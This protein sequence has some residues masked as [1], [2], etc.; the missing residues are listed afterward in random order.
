VPLWL[1]A[2][3]ASAALVVSFLVAGYFLTRDRAPEKAERL[4]P[5]Q[6]QAERLRPVQVCLRGLALGMLLLTLV[7]ALL[8]TRDPYRNFSM[9]A[10][11]ILF[12]LAFTY[13][14]ALVGNVYAAINPW[15]VLAELVGRWW[16]GYL[17]GRVRYPERLDAWP[18]LLLYFGFIAYE[19]FG[20]V[21]P[22]GFGH[23]LAGYTL[24]NLV[25][26]WLVGAQAWF[27]HGELFSVLLRLVALLAPV[28]ARREE[29]AVQFALRRPGAGA[30]M[31]RPASLALVLF[32]LF[33]LSS[34]AFDGLHA[35][36]PWFA[37]FW[38]DPL[39]VVTALAGAKPIE[40]YVSLLPWYKA[41]QLFCLA[42]SPLLYF[43][44]YLGAL[45]L[46]R[47]LAGSSRPLRE[48]ALDFAYTL[49]PIAFV[50]HVAHYWTLIL[51]Q[52]MK[53]LSLASDPFGWHWNLFGTRELFRAPLIPDL[54]L[55]WHVQVGLIVLGHVASVILAHRVA[56]WVFG[57][58]AMA[59]QVPMLA[60]M[61]AFTVFGLW[62]LAQPLESTL[63]R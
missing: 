39:G 26:V 50:Y 14:T 15:R 19:L 56:L 57:A 45:A 27:R 16:P 58:R 28:D 12:V 53:I 23:V 36:R 33:M 9:T 44:L 24:L 52:G 46:A 5:V 48:L 8:G 60:L 34:T 6:V 40:A 59:S 51:S 30:L 3:G 54:T 11:W 2:W 35:T 43:A 38:R 25:A 32:V 7:T 18:A 62:I 37:L 31:E 29:G 47:A 42:L 1:Y 4:R 41:W 20:F 10:F 13:L 22:P 49:L 63:V 61:V 21:R 17:A 55:T